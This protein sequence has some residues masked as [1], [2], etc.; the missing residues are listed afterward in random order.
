ME[1][2]PIASVWEITMGCNMRCSHC[3]SSCKDALPGQLE[4]DRALTLIDE[5]AEFGLRW[6]TLSGG[7]PLTHPHWDLLAAR[8]R[9]KGIE[10][11]MITNGSLITAEIAAKM[12]ECKLSTVAISV[13]GTKDV[14]DRIR[15]CGSYEKLEKGF[16]LLKVAGLF[17]GAITTVT[18][19]N[20]ELLPQI[21]DE[22][23]RMGV[24]AWQI[25]FGLPM[26]NLAEKRDKV[27][28]PSQIDELIDFCHETGEEGKIIIYP[29][30]CIG[31]YSR[32]EAASR[33]IAFRQPAVTLW[34]G[35]NAGVRGFGVLHNGDIVGCTSIRNEKF[36]EGNIKERN[37][38]SLW[39]DKK[40][41]GWRRKAAKE[42]LSGICGTCKYSVKCLGG[43]AN[44]R[45]TLGGDINAENEYC[46]YN[47][48]LR[49]NLKNIRERS[50]CKELY[51][52]ARTSVEQRETQYAAQLLN[53]V[54]ELHPEHLDALKLLGYAEFFNGNFNE[55][56][57]AN[58]KALELA[59]EDVYARSGLA[60]AV[61]KL[62]D[63]YEA[64]NLMEAVVRETNGQDAGFVNDLMTL[65][66]TAA[67]LERG[68]QCQTAT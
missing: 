26:G 27:I 38:R 47:F 10:T 33:Q 52:E 4:L 37:L 15:V 3:G 42:Q 35:C 45:L 9:D 58:E 57:T 24:D 7:E 39:E 34:D 51:I 17:C 61:S 5:M 32:K 43:C 2:K 1:Y 44:V 16:A 41:F 48:A 11:N 53:R 68:R 23:I 50:D 56:R 21:K 66:A 12:A 55:C 13:D 8:L 25:Q 18:K 59:P 6:I 60:M 31:Y 30:D 54:L 28:D 46:S 19:E 29:A 40:S 67:K 14:H 22:L 63:I 36:I 20:I 64:I 49:K 62:G 65:R